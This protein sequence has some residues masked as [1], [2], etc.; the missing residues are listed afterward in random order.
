MFRYLFIYLKLDFI[1]TIQRGVVRVTE[2]VV[3]NKTMSVYGFSN[4][5]DSFCSGI[6][7]QPH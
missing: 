6:A 5:S 1:Y 3:Y 4:P 2:H 7:P